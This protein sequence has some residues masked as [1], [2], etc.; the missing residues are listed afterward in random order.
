MILNRHWQGAEKTAAPTRAAVS[1]SYTLETGNFSDGKI[2][3]TA[4]S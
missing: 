1:N 2:S 4:R 3:R